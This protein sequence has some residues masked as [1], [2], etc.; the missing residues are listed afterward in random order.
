MMMKDTLVR[1]LGL[2]RLA[3]HA[4]TAHDHA[5]DVKAVVVYGQTCD[6][7]SKDQVMAE[8]RK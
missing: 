5:Q 4:G 6:G 2:S 3:R 7:R 8:D 1:L